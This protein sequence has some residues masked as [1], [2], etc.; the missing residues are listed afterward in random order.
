MEKLI[1]VEGM[2]CKSCELLLADVLG[3]I[4]GVQKAVADSRKGTVRVVCTADAT[5]EQVRGAIG[6]QGYRVID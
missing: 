1:R 6:K 5:L 3:E 2:H 4:D